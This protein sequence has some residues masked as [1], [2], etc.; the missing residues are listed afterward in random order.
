MWK[1]WPLLLCTALTLIGPARSMAQHKREVI[2]RGKKATALVEVKTATAQASGSAFCVAK[3]GLFITNAHV[4]RGAG[5]SKAEIRLVL[6]IGEK[7]QREGPVGLTVSSTGT[8][9]WSSPKGPADDEVVRVIVTV[10]NAS[11]AERFHTLR[12]HVE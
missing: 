9:T 5:A 7:T 2:D 11:G 3:S 8:L 1:P 4:I 6:D 12:I 10:A